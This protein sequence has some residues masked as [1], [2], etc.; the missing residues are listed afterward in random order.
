MAKRTKKNTRMPPPG[1]AAHPERR[2]RA[3]VPPPEPA[4]EVVGEVVPP[5]VGPPAPPPPMSWLDWYNGHATPDQQSAF[6]RAASVI[7]NGGVPY[8]KG[9][10]QEMYVENWKSQGPDFYNALVNYR[11]TGGR[12]ALFAVPP[13]NYGG[14]PISTVNPG[15]PIEKAG[16]GM[17]VLHPGRYTYSDVT[18]NGPAFRQWLAIVKSSVTLGQIQVSQAALGGD[19]YYIDYE[20][21]VDKDTAWPDAV[22]GQKL[23]GTPT[24]VPEG[25]NIVTYWGQVT[26]STPDWEAPGRALDRATQ[27]AEGVGTILAFAALGYVLLSLRPSPPP[28]RELR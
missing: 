15:G 2:R 20:F 1:P 10:S 13:K 28:P 27:I 23:H 6:D 9:G 8:K 17:L 14:K 5:T 16:A 18:A 7:D 25:I 4:P 22:A 24:W 21:L 12:R 19:P 26:K 11:D 3:P